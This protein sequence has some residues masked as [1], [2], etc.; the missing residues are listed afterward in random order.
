M[1]CFR[2]SDEADVPLRALVDLSFCIQA[3]KNLQVEGL[4]M[5]SANSELLAAPIGEPPSVFVFVGSSAE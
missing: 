3:T 1:I 2:S 4:I 5:D